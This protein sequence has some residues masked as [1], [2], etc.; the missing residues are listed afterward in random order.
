MRHYLC[1]LSA[2][3][4]LTVAAWSQSAKPTPT[5]KKSDS[6][7]VDPGKTTPAAN[8][9]S[10]DASSAT[11]PAAPK[12]DIAN[13]DKSIDPCVDFYQY[14][15]GNWMKNN[16]IPGDQSEWVSFNEVYEHNLI[17]LRQILEKAAA[18]TPGRTPIQQKIGDFYASCMDEATV[19][20]AGYTPLKP[21]LDRIA[22]IKDKTQMMEVVSHE[23]LIGPNP[24]MGFGSGPDLHNAEMTVASIDQSGL[25]LPDRDYYLKDD[26]PTLAIRKAY[27]E[28]MKKVFALAGQS[29]EQA[30][31]SADTV[32]K[33]ET[34]LAKAYMERTLRR[35]P[36]NR[37]HK[38][39]V[40]DAEALAPNFHLDRYFAVSGAPAFT[41]LNVGNPE[42]FKSVN[43]VIESTPL[44]AWKTYMT[45]QILNNAASWLSDD[46][47]QEDF[48]FQQAITGQQELPVRWKR[49]INATDNALGEALGQPYVDATFGADGKQRM[50]KMV[51]ALETA[52]K[53]DIH[54]LPWM[55]EATKKEGLVKLAAIRNKIGYPDKWRDYSKLTITRGDLLGN[56]YRASQFESNRQLQKIGKPVDKNEFGMTPPTVNAYYSGSHNEIVF[57][58]GILQPPFFDRTLDDAINMGGIGLVIGHE[59]THGFD[60]QGRKFDPKGNLRDWWTAEDGK[61]FEKRASCVADEYSSFTAVDDLKLNGRLTLGENTAD[62]GGAR[63]ALMALHDLMTQSKQDPDKKIDGY[64]PDQRFFLGF[65]RVWCQNTTPETSRMLVRVDPHSPGR[66]RVN[67][68]VRNMPEFQKAFGCKPGQP[69][70]PENACRVW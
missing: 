51:D 22:A 42:F 7:Q 53:A 62:N 68:V 30:T 24:L 41:E 60:D 6:K 26:A 18:N 39:S 54:D 32:L 70:A 31:Q 58:A 14:A 56:I 38:M 34:D 10:A 47:V 63:I 9:A 17:V 16:P 5:P 20:K 65:G 44:D 27:V 8:P 33:I 25:S 49:C 29:P 50:L 66:W 21:E 67:G 35:D 59:L 52:L 46:F 19:N 43:A 4:L 3:L 57:P 36:K 2:I 12:F 64:T 23:Q 37:D 15:C 55:S 1:Q 61:E 45:W 48:K 40:A 28:H 11:M 13:I 69:M